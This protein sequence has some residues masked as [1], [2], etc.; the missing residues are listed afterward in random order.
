MESYY[1]DK[2]GLIWAHLLAEYALKLQKV[3]RKAEAAYC[4]SFGNGGHGVTHD[5]YE[6]SNGDLM[7]LWFS[8]SEGIPMA[9]STSRPG[10][11]GRSGGSDF[12]AVIETTS[13]FC[14]VPSDGTIVMASPV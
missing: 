5:P 12:E 13:E 8:G 2:L 4:N 1:H 11:G 9:I 7:P 14:N 10:H 3:V 6:G